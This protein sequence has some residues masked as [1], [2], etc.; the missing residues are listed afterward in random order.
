MK[1]EV[2]VMAIES[3]LA[4]KVRTLLSM[5]GIVIG[6]STVIAVVGIGL[7]AEKNR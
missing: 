4:N 7:G 3:L 1:F 5:L 6:V 2:I